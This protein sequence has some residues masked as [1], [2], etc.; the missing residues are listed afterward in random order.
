MKRH[1][2]NIIAH[3]LFSGSAFMVIGLNGANALNYAYHILMVKFLDDPTHYGEL[4]ALISLIGLLGIIPGSLNLVVIKYISSAKNDNE[5]KMLTEWFKDKI[6]KISLAFFILIIALSPLITS[7]LHINKVWYVFLIGTS[8]LFSLPALLNRSI[9]QGLLKFKEMIFSILI[10]TG[11]KLILGVI[12]VYLGFSVGGA[13]VG[14]IVALIIGWYI[15]QIYVKKYMGN[16]NTLVPN[17]KSMALFALP[18][19]IQSFAITSLYSSD[20]ILVKHFF[21]SHEAGLYAALSTLGKIIFFGAGPISAVMFPLVSKKSSRGENYKKVFAYSFGAASL[22]AA[23][24]LLIYWFFPGFI[25]TT[26]SKSSYFEAKDLLFWYGLF[27]TL[28]TLSSILIS[29]NL[30]LGKARVAL[31]PLVAAFAQIILIWF[32]HQTLIMVITISILV[33]ALLLFALLVYSSLS[34][35]ISLWR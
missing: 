19:G 20:I 18:V 15:S 22:F 33:T 12:L 2:K 8:F 24:M 34:K 28:F 9:L 11:L 14:L 26:L 27:I 1:I 31:L 4:V 10:E 16:G 25:M 30:S 3:P 32:Y 17:I 6:L 7:F 5:V 21:T 29:Y 23:F 13:M 35:R